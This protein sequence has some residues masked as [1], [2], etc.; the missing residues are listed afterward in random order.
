MVAVELKLSL[1]DRLAEEAEAAG[2]LTAE[3]IESLLRTEVERRRHVRKLFAAAD[4]LATL[5][6]TL[7]PEEIEQE[8]ASVR[9]NRR[10]HGAGRS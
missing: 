5:E 3:A 9:A 6:P 8:I 2:L 4:R 10:Q 7:S 1:P